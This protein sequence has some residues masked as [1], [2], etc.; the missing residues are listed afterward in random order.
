MKYIKTV[1][2]FMKIIKGDHVSAYAA[3]A[4]YFIIMSCIP[5]IMLLMSIVQYTVVEYTYIT[6]V[7]ITKL[8]VSAVP[9]AFQ[10]TM[11][12]ILDDIYN[13]TTALVSITAITAIWSAGRSLVSITKG[14]NVIYEVKETRN[15]IFN[16]VRGA[17]YTFIFL[18]VILISM[19]LLVFGNRIH[20][21]IVHYWPVVARMTGLL[22]N[23][24]VVVTLLILT[25][26][27]MMVYKFL[28]NRHATFKS[29]F[30][31]ALITAI[32]WIVF[33]FGFSIYVDNFW[34]ASVLYGNLA[35]I[36]L[37]MVWLYFCIYIMLIGAVINAHFEEKVKYLRGDK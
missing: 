5:F 3:E 18:I 4:S 17:I 8:I 16:R 7:D 34:N 30:P 15:Y 20:I 32:S 36:T 24:R 10:G 1:S 27:F 6:R 22:M 9:I 25:L 33:S 26:A 21:T 12:A 23:I 35:T 19:L 28:P 14:L 2:S 13:H 11:L 29:Q 31:G 37:I